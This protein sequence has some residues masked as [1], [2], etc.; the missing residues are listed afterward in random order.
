MEPAPLSRIYDIR[1]DLHK[2]LTDLA[3]GL[4]EYPGQITAYAKPIAGNTRVSIY[5]SPDKK[6][7]R[8]LFFRKVL[9]PEDLLGDGWNPE[10]LIAEI[11]MLVMFR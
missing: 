2:T 7:G 11:T 3:K 9:Y 10:E 5:L 1:N 8:K 6:T 4:S